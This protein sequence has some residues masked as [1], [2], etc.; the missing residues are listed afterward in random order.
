MEE[1]GDVNSEENK[2]FPEKNRKRKLKTPFQIDALEKFYNEHKYPEESMKTELAKR[3]GLTEKQISGWFCHRRL[4]DKK[5]LQEEAYAHGKQDLSSGVI[6]DR[7]SGL[8]QDSCGSTKQEDYRLV[9]PREVESRRSYGEDL[10][11]ADGTYEN[12]VH[13]AGNLSGTDDTSSGTS[14]PLQD[15]FF[16]PSEDPCDMETSR[17]LAQYG[18]NMAIKAKGVKSRGHIGPS[19]Y[20]KVKGEVENAAITAVKRQLGRQ[21][22]EDG[23]SLGIEFQPLPPGAFGSPIMAPVNESYHAGTPTLPG[24]S[25]VPGVCKQPNLRAGYEG[26]NSKMG[27]L[28]SYMEGGNNE[29]IRG[30]DHQDDYSHH[31]SKK[32]S[33]SL[34][35]SDF[36]IGQDHAIDITEQPSASMHSSS[37]NYRR[38]K[39]G[40]EGVRLDSVSNNNLQHNDGK[41]ISGLKEPWLQN[42]GTESTDSPKIVIDREGFDSKRPSLVH[43]HGREI[44]WSKASNE[45]VW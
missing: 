43:R 26:Y 7:G 34:N 17:Y 4:K 37:R 2:V 8:R 6:Q 41:F 24:S 18:S 11:A 32:K 21:Y 12:R 44:L 39:H 36:L 35:Y 29:I 16:P 23:P 45:R 31:K 22:R 1:S 5:L 25:N 33:S 38:S 3:I 14:S 30:S 28:D 15:R 20:L 40:A 19:G 10:Q 13:C 42:Y 27:S 9:D